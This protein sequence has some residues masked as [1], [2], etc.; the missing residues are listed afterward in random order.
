MY[1]GLNLELQKKI[2][3]WK[4]EEFTSSKDKLEKLREDLDAGEGM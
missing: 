4:K 1:Y 3:V 2:S